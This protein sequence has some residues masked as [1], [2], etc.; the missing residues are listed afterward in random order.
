MQLIFPSDE[1]T[2]LVYHL[3]VS[4]TYLLEAIQVQLTYERRDFLVFEVLGQKR[5]DQLIVAVYN[6]RVIFFIPSN[7]M[8]DMRILT[9][10]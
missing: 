8:F 4:L 3:C 1:V 10:L 5:L 2:M 6:D 7:S 9:W